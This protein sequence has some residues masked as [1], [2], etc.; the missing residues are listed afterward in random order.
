MESVAENGLLPISETIGNVWALIWSSSKYWKIGSTGLRKISF[1]IEQLCIK[2]VRHRN[3]KGLYQMNQ[4]NMIT[5]VKSMV[6]K[7]FDRLSCLVYSV[8]TELKI[9]N[10]LMYCLLIRFIYFI[11]FGTVEVPNWSI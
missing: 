9:M 10:H 3:A 2:I 11:L 1:F 4:I 5:Q 7:D 6:S 8:E